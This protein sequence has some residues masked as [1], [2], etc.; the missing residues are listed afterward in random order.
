V[1]DRVFRPDKVL[2]TNLVQILITISFRVQASSFSFNLKALPFS[3][4]VS[5]DYSQEHKLVQEYIN[6]G[7]VVTTSANKWWSFYQLQQLPF[8]RSNIDYRFRAV[9]ASLPETINSDED[10]N[11]YQKFIDFYGTHFATSCSFGG[12]VNVDQFMDSTYY[13]G[14]SDEFRKSQLSIKF[15]IQ[16]YGIGLGLSTIKNNSHSFA[17]Y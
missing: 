4:S 1:L 17:M 11:K 12:Q 15:N 5:A 13:S 7:N 8:N 16:I 9:I 3:F 6:K 14:L 10:L 2:R